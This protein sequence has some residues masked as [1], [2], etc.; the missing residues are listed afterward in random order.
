MGASRR[1]QLGD[2]ETSTV[3]TTAAAPAA[4]ATTDADPDV[5]AHASRT[6]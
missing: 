5:R 6:L 3:S 1:G 4:L 2:A